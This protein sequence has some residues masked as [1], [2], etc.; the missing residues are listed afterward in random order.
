MGRSTPR[1]WRPSST[2]SESGIRPGSRTGPTERVSSSTVRFSNCSRSTPARARASRLYDGRAPEDKMVKRI[3][4]M[5]KC[6]KNKQ[7]TFED[8]FQM[9]QRFRAVFYP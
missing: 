5:G 7:V 2:H 6:D 3:L 9:G 4:Q 1:R 8:L